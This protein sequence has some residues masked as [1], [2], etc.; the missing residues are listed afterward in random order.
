M[1][2]YLTGVILCIALLVAACGTDEVAP[3][4]DVSMG[5]PLNPIQ[6][7]ELGQGASLATVPAKGRFTIINLWASWCAPCRRELPSLQLLS[8]RLD[9]KYFQVIGI[10]VDEDD[11]IVREYLLDR[12]V[13]FSNFHDPSGI[14]TRREWGPKLFPLTYI[15]DEQGVLLKEVVGERTWGAYEVVAL[16]NASR[17]NPS[18]LQAANVLDQ[19]DQSELRKSG[20][21][22]AP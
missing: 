1:N 10:S 3:L 5:E 21:V 16:L 2:S 19:T 14:E 18:L 11:H 13:A 17:E 12:G 9:R 20:A 15:V 22:V 7:R 8:E 4:S 6:V